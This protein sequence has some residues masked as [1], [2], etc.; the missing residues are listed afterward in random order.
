MKKEINYRPLDGCNKPKTFDAR[1]IV[2]AI[3]F[4]VNALNIAHARQRKAG[5]RNFST[6]GRDC[7]PSTARLYLDICQL[8]KLD[9]NTALIQFL[10]YRA[11]Y[12]CR[13]AISPCA[14]VNADYFSLQG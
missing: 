11:D 9:F 7:I 6:F 13:I 1:C 10:K 8:N 3:K 14:T 4:S 12:D 5:Y 2:K